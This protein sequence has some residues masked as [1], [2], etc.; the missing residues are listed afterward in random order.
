[1]TV[2]RRVFGVYL[3]ALEVEK[4]VVYELLLISVTKKRRELKEAD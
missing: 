2:N 3:I 1:M 4:E